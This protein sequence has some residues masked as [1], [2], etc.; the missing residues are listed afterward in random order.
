M[1]KTRSR[2]GSAQTESVSLSEETIVECALGLAQELGVQGLTVRRIG[3]E[4]GADPTAFYRYFRDKDELLLACMDRVTDRAFDRFSQQAEGLRPPQDWR[5]L[6]RLS[7]H[8]TWTTAREYPA[9]TAACF[10][11]VTG[12][13]AERR[14][15]EF[16]V[17]T[18]SKLGLGPEEATLYYR[19]LVD[20]IL[21]MSGLRATVETLPEPEAQKNVSAWSTVYG[22]VNPDTYPMIFSHARE[23][24]SVK[25]EAIFAIVIESILDRIELVSGFRS[26]EETSRKG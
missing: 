2:A 18:L 9:I 14:W 24:Q 5:A 3:Q 19:A 25:P 6:L 15:V 16:F 21:S 17:G 8:A 20:A 10:S 4:L 11:R 13:A 7:A 26:D 1:A 12:R 22:A 23:L